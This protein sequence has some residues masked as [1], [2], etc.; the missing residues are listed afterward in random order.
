M[1]PLTKERTTSCIGSTTYDFSQSDNF[2]CVP[3]SSRVV[4]GR[5]P[6]Q[7]LAAAGSIIARDKLFEYGQADQ[8]SVR[9]TQKVRHLAFLET[10]YPTLHLAPSALR[11]L[12]STHLSKPRIPTNQLLTHHRHHEKVCCPCSGCVWPLA[13]SG[14][15]RAGKQQ[16]RRGSC[17]T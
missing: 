8:S 1:S 16:R 2:L 14:R 5:S 6:D 3:T 17:R 13:A 7:Q 11:Q 15:R 4:T 10:S 9:T 12:A